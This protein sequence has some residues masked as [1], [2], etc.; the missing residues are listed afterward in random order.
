MDKNCDTAKKTVRSV[1]MRFVLYFGLLVCILA[2]KKQALVTSD[3]IGLCYNS[4]DVFMNVSNIHN[5]L[6]AEG[7]VYSSLHDTSVRKVSCLRHKR[8]VIV[9]MLL[10][11]GD[12]NHVPGPTINHSLTREEFKQN[13]S[14]RGFKM[15]PLVDLYITS[16][17]WKSILIDIKEMIY[18]A[19]QER[20][21]PVTLCLIHFC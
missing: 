16:M 6:F 20:I 2:L 14:T 5:E 9:L 21:F 3:T 11:S 7:F 12:I 15:V 1:N 13:L 10:F 19:Y 4:V 8:S 18:L 17:F